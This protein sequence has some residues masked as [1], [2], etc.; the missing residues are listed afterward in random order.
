MDTGRQ[1]VRWS[2][3]GTVFLLALIFVLVLFVAFNDLNTLTKIFGSK[4]SAKI[5]IPYVLLISSIIPLGFI[6]YQVYYWAYGNVVAIF[7]WVAIDKGA[8]ILKHLDVETRRVLF[9]NQRTFSSIERDVEPEEII[10]SD[11]ETEDV[12]EF[13]HFSYIVDI[14]I[15]GKFLPQIRR[16]KENFRNSKGRRSYKLHFFGHWDMV[17]Y[18][19]HGREEHFRK[20]YM[21]HFDIFH[22]LGA[23]NIAVYLATFFSVVGVYCLS[24][25]GIV[26]M[27][28][29]QDLILNGKLTTFLILML[30]FTIKVI[31]GNRRATLYSIIALMKH[32][33]HFDDSNGQKNKVKDVEVNGSE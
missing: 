8:I 21:N 18:W 2:I 17:R 20:E 10:L 15:L 26:S 28:T 11:T 29:T 24:E 6:I 19:V 16:L 30:L 27:T 1:I 3:P 31:D 13:D 23:C 7:N 25:M 12:K 5:T 22:A 4:A 14:W 9:K 32:Q 33:A